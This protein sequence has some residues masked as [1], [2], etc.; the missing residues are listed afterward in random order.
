MRDLEEGHGDGDELCVGRNR[1]VEDGAGEIFNVLYVC[2]SIKDV[3]P[4]SGAP[5]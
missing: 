4:M 5:K 1:V 2:C 3:R